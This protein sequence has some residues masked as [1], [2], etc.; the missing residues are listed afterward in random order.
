MKKNPLESSP[1]DTFPFY[2]LVVR[3]SFQMSGTFG[4]GSCQKT[5]TWD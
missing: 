1:S 5:I 2:S 3:P 4:T